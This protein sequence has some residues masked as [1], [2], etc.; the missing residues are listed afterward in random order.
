MKE[1][2]VEVKGLIKRYGRVEALAGADFAA[3]AGRITVFMGENGA[4]KTTALKCILGFLRPDR[5]LV[6]VR[7]KRAGYIPEHPVSFSWLTGREVLSLTARAYGIGEKSFPDLVSSGAAKLSFDEGLLSRRVQTYS[8]GSQKKFSYLQNLVISPELL[9][10]DEPFS[11]LD[12]ASIKGV[13]ELFL[14][15]KRGG[16]TVFLSSHLISEAEKIADDVIII[17][18]GRVCFQSALAEDKKAGVTDLESLFMS[19]AR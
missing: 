14:E 4:G 18:K 17:K 5:G 13:R 8:Q 1:P 12:P 15:I 10:V 16:G 2:I 11:G 7:A 9:I 19:Y 3:F 6:R